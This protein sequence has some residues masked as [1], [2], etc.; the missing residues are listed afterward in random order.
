MRYASDQDVLSIIRENPGI[1]T[2][3]ISIRLYT[4][5]YRRDGWLHTIGQLQT[6][7]NKGLIRGVQDPEIGRARYLWT[8]V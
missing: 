1:T 5:E 3:K 4:P 8:V 7:K 6:L 2:E